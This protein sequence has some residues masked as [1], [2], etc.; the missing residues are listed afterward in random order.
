MIFKHI[1]IYISRLL[2]SQLFFLY[3]ESFR[4]SRYITHCLE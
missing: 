1:L 3:G 2:R 4:L